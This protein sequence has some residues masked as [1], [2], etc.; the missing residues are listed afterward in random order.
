MLKYLLL[1]FQWPDSCTFFFFNFLS[2][3]VYF[4]VLKKTF[5][6]SHAKGESLYFGEVGKVWYPKK[7]E[8]GIY[9]W[10]NHSWSFSPYV[11]ML[12]QK[13]NDAALEKGGFDC[14]PLVACLVWKGGR[15]FLKML[16]W[17]PKSVTHLLP[18]L[19]WRDSLLQQRT[20]Q[21]PKGKGGC[22][23]NSCSSLN[24]YFCATE[25]YTLNEVEGSYW[26]LLLYEL[27]Y[28]VRVFVLSYH[29]RRQVQL[30]KILLNFCQNNF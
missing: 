11:S 20:I 15:W 30:S 16:F 28:S 27:A 14:E 9:H 17:H 2:L 26:L 1:V 23:V 25:K 29:T 22:L 5:L 7:E 6:M 21:F 3:V 10:I 19:R 18:Q 12:T 4:F 13:I 24:I 8:S